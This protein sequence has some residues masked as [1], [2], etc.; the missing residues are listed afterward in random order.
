MFVCLLNV[1][2][3]QANKQV[4]RTRGT[5]LGK[6]CC[7]QD[8]PNRVLESQNHWGWN[9]LLSPV[10]YLNSEYSLFHDY[11]LNIGIIDLWNGLSWKGP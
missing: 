3:K 8:M 11:N 7:K 5:E 6:K 4:N 10:L 9:I 1:C 2:N